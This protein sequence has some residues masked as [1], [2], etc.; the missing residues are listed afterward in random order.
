MLGA[1]AHGVGGVDRDRRPVGAEQVVRVLERLPAGGAGG[2]GDGQQRGGGRDAQGGGLVTA[3]RDHLDVL[4]RLVR[5]YAVVGLQQLVEGTAER[6]L[7]Q[8]GETVRG[9][10]GVF[11]RD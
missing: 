8:A 9:Q 1:D 2:A 11:Q 4:D 3:R 10:P 5:A 7:E 6:Q